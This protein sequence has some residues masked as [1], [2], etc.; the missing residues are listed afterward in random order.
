MRNSNLVVYP[1][2]AR[3]VLKIES[4]SDLRNTQYQIL[5]L[6][7]NIVLEAA[8]EGKNEINVSALPNGIY[9]LHLVSAKFT[10][11]RKFTLIK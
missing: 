3:N 9:V 2:P 4:S 1:N 5:D 7:G 8:L 11:S 10:T 6:T